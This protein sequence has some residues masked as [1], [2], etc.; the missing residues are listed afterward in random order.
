MKRLQLLACVEPVEQRHADVHD[1]ELG[2]QLCGGFQQ[3]PPV[4][5]R[6]DDIEFGLQQMLQRF[7]HQHVI[8]SEQDPRDVS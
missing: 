6:A 4:R 3:R 2:L 8:V 5:D 7:G 1:D